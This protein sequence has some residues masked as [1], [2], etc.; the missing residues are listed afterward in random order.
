MKFIN[1]TILQ[2]RPISVSWNIYIY[3]CQLRV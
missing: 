3:P 1:S 2:L